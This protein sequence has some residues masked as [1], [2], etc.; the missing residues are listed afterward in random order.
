MGKLAA[1]VVLGSLIAAPFSASADQVEPPNPV[2]RSLDSGKT[3]HDAG[4]VRGVIDSVDYSVGML[5][6]KTQHG[7]EVITVVPTTA[8][9]QGDQYATLGDLRRGQS[10]TVSVYEV[11]GRLVAQMIRLK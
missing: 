6:V 2:Y 9:Y 8:I 1:L 11:G 5:V 10:V 4:V 7:R 3:V